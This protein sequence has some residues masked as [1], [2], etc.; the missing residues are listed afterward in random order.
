MVYARKAMWN[1]SSTML[2]ENTKGYSK[3]VTPRPPSSRMILKDSFQNNGLMKNT[4]YVHVLCLNPYLKYVHIY[5]FFFSSK[6][7]STLTDR[8]VYTWASTMFPCVA[9]EHPLW[10]QITHLCEKNVIK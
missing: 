8:S 4:P 9:G 10:P 6:W 1:P 2:S 3:N 7:L 5:F